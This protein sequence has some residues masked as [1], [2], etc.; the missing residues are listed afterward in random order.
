ML[1]KMSEFLYSYKNKNIEAHEI[2]KLESSFKE[3]STEIKNSKFYDEFYNNYLNIKG[4]TYRLNDVNQRL[5]YTFQEAV[6]AI[7]LAKLMRDEASIKLNSIVYILVI[8]DCINEYLGNEIDEELKNK[9]ISF[10]E[11]EQLRVSKE[12]KKYHM[13]QN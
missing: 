9:A 11:K 5:F 2:S 7:D 8:N 4:Y 6:Y 12:N 1:D 10:Y 3:F 13:Y